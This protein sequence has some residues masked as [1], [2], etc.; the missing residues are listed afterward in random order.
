MTPGLRE[1]IETDRLTLRPFALGDA[2]RVSALAG[3]PCVARMTL[4][5]PTPYPVLAAEGWILTHAAGRRRGSDFPFAV[6][7]AGAGLV[8]AAGLHRRGEGWI[9]GYWIGAPYR[10]RGYAT[11]AAR[12]LTAEAGGRLGLDALGAEWFEDNPASGRVLEKAGFAPTGAVVERFSLGRG[13]RAR[14]V[15]MEWRAGA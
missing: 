15:A 1:R 4:T 11:E 5:I 13:A 6:E 8:G 3:A 7:A 9:L 10:G 14:A 2:P 12:A